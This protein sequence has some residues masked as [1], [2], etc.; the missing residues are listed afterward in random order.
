MNS[1]E[2]KSINHIIDELRDIEVA[3][4]RSIQLANLDDLPAAKKTLANV[5]SWLVSLKDQL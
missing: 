4:D 5:F 2:L 3:I 1:L